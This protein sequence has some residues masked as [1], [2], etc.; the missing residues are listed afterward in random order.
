M[1]GKNE[2]QKTHRSEMMQEGLLHCAAMRVWDHE[3]S[4]GDF[5][6]TFVHSHSLIG[7]VCYPD[8]QAPGGMEIGRKISGDGTPFK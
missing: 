6:W 2:A 7:H 8:R 5:L 1:Q 3:T 4:L